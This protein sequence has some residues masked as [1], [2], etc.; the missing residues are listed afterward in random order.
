M[1]RYDRNWLRIVSGLR[2][3][4]EFDVILAEIRRRTLVHS[5]LETVNEFRT[6]A[7]D[8]LQDTAK[9]GVVGIL[10]LNA[11]YLHNIMWA[12]GN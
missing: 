3:R 1:K 7:G 11:G 10:Y 4:R 9:C 12:P 5:L 2:R 8:Q 6:D